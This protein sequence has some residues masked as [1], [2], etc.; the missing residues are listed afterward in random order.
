MH[1]AA[2]RVRASSITM[3]ERDTGFRP[4][5]T[6][7]VVIVAVAVSAEPHPRKIIFKAHFWPFVSSGLRFARTT[8]T[9]ITH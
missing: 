2:M 9:A 8:C 1:L 3:A 6:I 5:G 7:V 4:D